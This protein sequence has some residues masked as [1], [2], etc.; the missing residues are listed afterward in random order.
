[1]L[2]MDNQTPPELPKNEKTPQALGGL[3]R[4]KSLS[5]NDLRIQGKNAAKA[6][7]DAARN[8]AKA[9][10]DPTRTPEALCEGLL[11]IGSVQIE[12]YVLDSLK[13]VIHKR[14]MAKALGM[15]SEGGN[16]FMKT[17]GRKGLG[18]QIGE[19]LRSKLDNPII[20]KTLTTDPGHGYDATILIDICAAILDASKAGRLGAGQAALAVQAE[21]IIRASAKLGIVAMV[22]EA[23]GFIADKRREKYKDLF[24]EFIREEIRL[25][26]EPQF[27]DQLFDVIYKI[28][29]LPRKADSNTHPQ[30]FG[31][32]IRKYIYQPL[33][34]S[35]GAILE[36]LDE[37]N[38][39]VYVNGGRRY[40]MYNFLSEVV[41][42]PALKSHFWQV[43]GIGN[44]VKGK[45]QFERSFYTAFPGPQLELFPGFQLE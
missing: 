31:K 41:G 15:K 37:K 20:F 26:D 6:R 23:T 1:M 12:C 44:S 14:G 18:S 17:M 3:A 5:Q 10:E 40:K 25:Y 13:R 24:R 43:I 42:M 9:L 30:F 28:Y 32:F 8:A 7:W 45:A 35:N 38:P 29:G 34:N 16:A 4:A 19:D 2:G 39:V 11:E 33:A 27:P 21:I 22:D 36:M